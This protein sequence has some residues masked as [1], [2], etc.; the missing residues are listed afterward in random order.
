MLCTVVIPYWHFG[1]WGQPIAPIYKG[2]KI[3]LGG[4]GQ[5]KL[6][7]TSVRKHFQELQ[8]LGEIKDLLAVTIYTKLLL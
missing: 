4:G 5:A 3:S 6:C 2:Q 8:V 1:T 7:T